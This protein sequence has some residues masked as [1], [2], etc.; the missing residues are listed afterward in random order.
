MLGAGGTVDSGL[1]RQHDLPADSEVP[2]SG[3]PPSRRKR[4][5]KPAAAR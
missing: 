3:A 2:R 1:L 4:T 5:T